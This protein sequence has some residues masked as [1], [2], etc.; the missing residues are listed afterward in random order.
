[1]GVRKKMRKVLAAKLDE[2]NWEDPK[3]AIEG[4]RLLRKLFAAS[5]IGS[6]PVSAPGIV[7]APGVHTGDS[8]PLPGAAADERRRHDGRPEGGN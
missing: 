8:R 3:Q 1:M 4:N 2:V 5:P 6:R 7:D